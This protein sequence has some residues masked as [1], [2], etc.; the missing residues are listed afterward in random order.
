MASTK[1]PDTIAAIATASG[2]GGIGVVRVSGPAVQL[3][4]TQV[5][6]NCPAPRHASYLDF[7]QANGDLIDRGIAIFYPN[8][9]SYTG[10]DVLELQ[11]HGGTALMQILLAVK[12]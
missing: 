11:A 3:I 6:G 2:A 1:L 9:H 4:A 8:P 5:L 7:K 10:E 12:M